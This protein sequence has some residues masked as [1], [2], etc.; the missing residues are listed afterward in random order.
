MC[1][2]KFFN[3]V[4]VTHTQ[5]DDSP[6]KQNHVFPATDRIRDLRNTKTLPHKHKLLI[7]YM[8]V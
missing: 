2:C 8:N 1:M 5:S 3:Y 6:V 7:V 4:S